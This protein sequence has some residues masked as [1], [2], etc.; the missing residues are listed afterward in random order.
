M[1]VQIYKTLK[2]TYVVGRESFIKQI[3]ILLSN[4]DENG[5][6]L[7]GQP[8]IGKTSALDALCAIVNQDRIYIPVYLDP[9][10]L[11]DTALEKVVSEIMIRIAAEININFDI[12]KEPLN[13][14]ETSFL[15]MIHDQLKPNQRLIVC[16]DEFNLRDASIHP[17]Y[18]WLKS[19]LPNLNSEIFFIL[20]GGRLSSDIT[21]I[22]LPFFLAFACITFLQCPLKKQELWYVILNEITQSNGRKKSLVRFMNFLVD[23]H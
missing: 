17:F 11:D 21:D 16:I 9:Q 13:D 1:F 19:L 22:F 14:F 8:C 20:T 10:T 4:P 3:L 15:P 6:F 23:T 7:F 5:A 2:D 12:S 18:L